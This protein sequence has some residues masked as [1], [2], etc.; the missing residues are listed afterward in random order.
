MRE[1]YAC[2]QCAGS[3]R[4]QAQAQTLVRI[5]SREGARCL[6]ELAEEREFRSLAIYEPGTLGPF[7]TVFE[8]HPCY[9]TSAYWP[10]VPRGK[11]RDGIRCEDLMSLTYEEDA[12]DLVITSDIFEHVRKPL[13]GFAEVARVLRPHGLHVFSI[14]VEHP[15]PERSVHRVDTSGPEDIPILEPVHHNGHLVYTDFGKD[16]LERLGVMGSPTEA[17]QY[18]SP[19]PVFDRVLTFVSVADRDGARAAE[20]VMPRGPWP[21]RR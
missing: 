6:E 4:Y 11:L 10:D 18:E 13:E 1:T 17:V 14:P 2:P 7:R 3:L 8:C 15:L 5:L 19:E 21:P 20:G 9:E 16:L 12:F